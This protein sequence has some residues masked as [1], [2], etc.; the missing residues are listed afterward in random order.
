MPISELNVAK[1]ITKTLNS[2]TGSGIIS[3]Y[4]NS[5]SVVGTDYK[6]GYQVISCNAFLKNLKAYAKIDSLEEAPLPEFE[7]GDSDTQKLYKTLDVEWG[8]PRKQLN[9]FI[10]SGSTDWSPVGSISLLNP[11]GYPYRLYSLM[12]LYTDALSFELGTNSSI[13]L[14][15]QDVGYGLL[16]GTDVVTIHGSYVEEYYLLN[17]E[18]PINININGGS[19][20]PTQTTDTTIGNSTYIDNTFLIGN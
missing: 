4:T 18:P 5:V 6:P 19:T 17:D 9:L 10:K 1:T 7:L 15:I 12:D 20:A 14:Q 16:S 2:T 8:S 11:Y 13:G 3:V